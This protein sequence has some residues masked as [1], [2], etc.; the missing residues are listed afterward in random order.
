V[1]ARCPDSEGV[2]VAPVSDARLAQVRR[3]IPALQHRRLR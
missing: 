2:C 1:L 3:E